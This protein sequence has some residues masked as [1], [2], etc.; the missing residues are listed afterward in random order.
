MAKQNAAWLKKPEKQDYGNALDYL[1]L[2]NPARRAEELVRAL[3]KAKTVERQAKDLLRA[4]A[5]PLLPR[6]NPHVDD[7]LKKLRKGKPLSPILLVR[8]DMTKGTPLTVADGYHRIC[9]IYY[10][11][12]S[13]P[14]PCRI[15]NLT[16]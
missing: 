14:L 15:A 16:H 10:H 2:I 8:G 13:A 1:T 5:L 9:A 12:E 6:E 7:D 4:S 11:D 3:R